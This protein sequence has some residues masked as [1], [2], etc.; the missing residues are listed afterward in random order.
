MQDLILDPGILPRAEGSCS[1][2]SHPGVP[3][4]EILKGKQCFDY[5]KPLYGPPPSRR[6][7]YSNST[8]RKVL[9]CSSHDDYFPPMHL[10]SESYDKIANSIKY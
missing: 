3:V 10:V 2:L 5:V 8:H 6:E 9:L 7:R 1:T 4:T